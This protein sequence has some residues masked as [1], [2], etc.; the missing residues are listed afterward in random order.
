MQ[1][2][3]INDFI[4]IVPMYNESESIALIIEK[5]RK[6]NFPF[7][8]IDNHSTDGC[9][10]IALELGAEVY[11][12]DEYGNGYG[13]A[14]MKGMDIA[15]QKGYTYMG[16][17]DCDITYN[18]EYFVEMTQFTPQYDL[19]L[20]VRAY[21][22]I[23]LIRRIGNKIHT[24]FANLLYGSHLKDVNTGLRIINIGKFKP[25]MTEK[26]MGMM[27]QITSFALRNRLKIKEISIQYEARLGQSKLNKIK[28]GWD[29]LLA[30]WRER[31]KK[32]VY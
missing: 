28:D 4:V 7:I 19:V 32:R 29:I 31:L 11:Q 5:L 21:K 17:I 30:I 14:I 10:E 8:V 26:Y 12:R 27:P 25:Y 24:L 23:S 15:K 1:K 16:I 2:S 20:G 22:D 9:Y 18:S 13:C 3:K 6:L